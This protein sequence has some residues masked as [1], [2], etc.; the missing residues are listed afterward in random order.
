M[1]TTADRIAAGNEYVAAH[2]YALE[3]ATVRQLYDAYL[4]AY[5]DLK[6][7]L[8]AAFAGQETWD[9]SRSDRRDL[10]LAQIAQQMA[11]LDQQAAAL[12]LT[13]AENG[14]S[15][16]LYGAA[17]NMDTGF[18]I[19]STLPLL[20][21]EAVRAQILAPYEGLTF[22]E[23]FTDNRADFQLRVKRSLVQSQIQGET[24]YE[25]QK[26]LA[27]ALGI[28]IGRRT[29]ADRASNRAAFARTEMIAR[30]EILRAS[31]NGALATYQANSDV[32]QGYEIKAALD[33]RTCPQCGALDGK[34]YAFGEGQQPPFHVRC[35]CTV[36]P[37]LIDTALMDKVAGKRTT[38]NEWAAQ[39]GLTK[40]AYGQAFDYR[41]QAAPKKPQA[42]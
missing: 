30:T 21:S 5:R 26:R 29:K 24:I 7:Q 27:E 15:A 39:R 42:A 1:T 18:G 3:A 19:N 40:N 10:L 38:F 14:H 25:A 9:A 11:Q 12:T 4:Q 33:E 17:W 2:I 16:G 31:N 6:S 20:P 37:V 36:I 8:E 41:G 34:R 13:A 22:V 35:R 23:R 28:A 32:L